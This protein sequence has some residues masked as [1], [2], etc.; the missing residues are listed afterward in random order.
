MTARWCKNC[1]RPD[2]DLGLEE[3]NRHEPGTVGWANAMASWS[4][5]RCEC[6]TPEWDEED[7]A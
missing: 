6:A 3:M 4:P 5:E 2:R 7:A 1:H